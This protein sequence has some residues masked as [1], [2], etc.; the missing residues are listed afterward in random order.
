M[1]SPHQPA[2]DG[3]FILGTISGIQSITDATVKAALKLPVLPKYTTVQNSVVSQLKQPTAYVAGAAVTTLVING[4]TV[5]RSIYTTSGTWTRPTVPAGFK[6]SRIGAAAINGGDGGNGPTGQM[7]GGSEGGEGGGYT[8]KE[9]TD[10][11]VPL[12]VNIAVGAGGNGGGQAATGQVGGISSFGTLVTGKRGVANVLTAQGAV[13]S[14]GAPG[15]GGQGGTGQAAFNAVLWLNQSSPGFRGAS[16][17]LAVGGE[18]GAIESDGQ[19]G[20]SASTDAQI[21]SGGGAGGGGG[22]CGSNP[23]DTLGST[24]PGAGGNGGAPG[25][26]GGGAGGGM[27]GGAATFRAGGHGANGAVIVWVYFEPIIVPS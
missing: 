15:K 6:I 17:A 26:G 1:T 8:Y 4:Q 19:V 13:G 2:P 12:S 14:T 24:R 23:L 25:G 5:T 16:T 22:G 20:G 9:F 11:I 10:G 27:K 3:S 21:Y 18:G 7:G